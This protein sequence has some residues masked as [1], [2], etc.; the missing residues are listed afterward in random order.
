MRYLIDTNVLI[1]TIVQDDRQVGRR[2]RIHRQEAGLS[3]IVLHELYFGAYDSERR[4]R[5]LEVVHSIGLPLIAFEAE[6][7]RAAARIRADQRRK[8][9]PIGPYDLLIAGQALAR[10]LILVTANV[11]EFARVEGLAVE[12]W[13]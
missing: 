3:A 7:A 5:S 6:D 12:D 1:A 4:K 8:G 9:T 10:G 11:R 2:L 13:R